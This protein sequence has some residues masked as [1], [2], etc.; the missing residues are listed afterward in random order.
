MDPSLRELDISTPD[1]YTALV[2]DIQPENLE[3]YMS[4]QAT[5]QELYAQLHA[6]Q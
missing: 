1:T 4:L 6:L 5:L 3:K 2:A